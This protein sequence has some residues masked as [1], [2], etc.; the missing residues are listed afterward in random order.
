[1]TRFA[2]YTAV[3]LMRRIIYTNWDTAS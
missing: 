3:Q 1:M 2:S